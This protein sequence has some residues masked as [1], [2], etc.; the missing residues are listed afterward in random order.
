MP[1]YEVDMK[2]STHFSLEEFLVSQ[3]AERHG[4]DM[5]PPPE[6]KLNIIRLVTD[7]LQPLRD[8]MGAPLMINSGY[9]PEDLNSLIGGSKTSAHRFGCA[10]DVRSNTYSPLDLCHLVVDHNLPF[11][12]VIHEFG[13]WMHVGIRW[14]DQP[15][16]KQQLTA[17]RD[18]K[19]SKTKYTYGLHRIEDLVGTTEKLI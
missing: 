16:R 7:L 17:Y 2:I 14:D 12:Q 19:T 15:I 6:I 10:A 8:A 5:T 13:R 4:I 11:D 9:R 3:T 18:P 1:Y